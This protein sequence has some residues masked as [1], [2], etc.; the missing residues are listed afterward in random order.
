M[1]RAN[2]KALR[3]YLP[4]PYPGRVTLFRAAEAAAQP[5]DPTF[6]WRGLAA[7]G[8]EVHEVPGDHDTMVREPHVRVLAERLGAQLERAGH[9]MEPGT[10]PIASA[11]GADGTGPRTPAPRQTSDGLRND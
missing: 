3:S 4:G 7:G 10:G 1:L 2:L 11:G 9:P 5:P 6:G 8:V